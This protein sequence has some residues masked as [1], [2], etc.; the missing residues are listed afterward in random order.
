MTVSD[1]KNLQDRLTVLETQL[2]ATTSK[3]DV[4]QD[5]LKEAQKELKDHAKMLGKLDRKY[6][7]D[8]DE[9]RRCTLLID[10][11]NERDNKRPKPVIESL[12]KDLGVDHKETDIRAA[13]R[14]GPVRIGISRP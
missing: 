6:T 5:Q 1:L 12:L 4:T 14:L 3:L 11:V 10:R 13:Y 8:E 9:F 2:T 7:E